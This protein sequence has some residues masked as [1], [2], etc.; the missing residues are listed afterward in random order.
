MRHQQTPQPPRNSAGF[1]GVFAKLSDLFDIDRLIAAVA[2]C[3]WQAHAG[4]VRLHDIPSASG[5]GPGGAT[6][7]R[8]IEP[9]ADRAGLSRVGAWLDLDRA[10]AVVDGCPWNAH[11]GLLRM[12]DG[13][14]GP[15]PPRPS[16]PPRRPLYTPEERVRRDRSPWTLVQGVLAPLQFLVFLVSLWLV[17]SYLMTGEGLAAANISVV[18]KTGI[19]YTIMVTGS[20]WEKDVFGKWL[21]APAFFWEDV[22]SMLVIALHTAYIGAL[23]FGWLDGRELMI[24]ALAAYAAYVVNAVQ[25]LL[26]LRAA[27]RQEARESEAAR[28]PGLVK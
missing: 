18:I 27:R 7:L 14:G 23:L 9:Q 21:F 15:P 13:A 4:E 22:F 17:I 2:S 25:F 28:T 24:L 12:Q 26:K 11:A 3:P 20:I 10:F 6:P 19:L 1:A 8:R 16:Q 5:D